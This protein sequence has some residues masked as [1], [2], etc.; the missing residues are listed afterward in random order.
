[1]H[2]AQL[3]TIEH[4]EEHNRAHVHHHVTKEKLLHRFQRNL[5]PR[6]QDVVL[7]LGVFGEEQEISEQPKYG[8]LDRHAD[9][10][11]HQL[12]A[13]VL[14]RGINR[15]SAN[16]LEEAFDVFESKHRA[17]AFYGA[18]PVACK[19]VSTISS[20]RASRPRPS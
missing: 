17:R 20:T 18:S 6:A 7:P 13:M 9:V 3:P 5:H 14:L 2:H 4:Q 15:R 11:L 10:A 12:Q 8:H 16:Q 1:M 19:A